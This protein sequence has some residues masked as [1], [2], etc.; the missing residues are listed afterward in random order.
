VRWRR[1]PEPGTERRF[2]GDEAERLA[3]RINEVEFI[4]NGV[5][6]VADTIT[7]HGRG[8]A[9]ARGTPI[10]DLASCPVRTVGISAHLN[11]AACLGQ[12]RQRHGVVP[13]ADA[14]LLL[15]TAELAPPVEL[16]EYCP[17]VAVF[18]NW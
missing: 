13:R 16:Y 1:A 7:L 9:F 10:D 15:F 14:C 2:A 11:I 17:V 5:A 12:A 3:N 6:A 4:I 18:V 8:R